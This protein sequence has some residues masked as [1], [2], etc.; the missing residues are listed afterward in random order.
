MVMSAFETF[1]P[2]ACSKFF[3]LHERRN[4]STTPLS[5]LSLSSLFSLFS[6]Q[7]GEKLSQGVFWTCSPL[8]TVSQQKM[9]A[10]GRP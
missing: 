3:M 2:H 9:C 8:P 1:F 5:I 10:D 7:L 4:S 6:K